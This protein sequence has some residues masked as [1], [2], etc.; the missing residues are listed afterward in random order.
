MT[1]RIP[2]VVPGTRPEL[3]AIEASILAE[4]GRI[5]LLYQVLL[6]SAPLAQGWEKLLTAIRNHNSMPADLREM[7]MVRVAVL[8]RAPFEIDAH[9]PLAMKAGVSVEKLEALRAD[10]LGAVF[11]Q[12]EHAVLALTD[13]MTRNVQVPDA[14]FEPLRTHFD[15]RALLELVATVAAYNM[16]SRLLEA[17]QIGH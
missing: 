10:D 9:I 4:R 13:A 2:P 7:V 14:I 17:L 16:V 8:N 5:N 1:P 15:A 3:N 6:N 11:T 12:R